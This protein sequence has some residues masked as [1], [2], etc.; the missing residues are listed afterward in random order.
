MD[1]HSTPGP[2]SLSYY[3]ELGLNCNEQEDEQDDPTPQSLLSS[4]QSNRSDI[5][6]SLFHQY[7]LTPL[8]GEPVYFVENLD[9]T[10]RVRIRIPAH[11]TPGPEHAKPSATVIR[12]SSFRRYAL[13]YVSVYWL[14]V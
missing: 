14:C 5:R 9:L 7:R 8:Y 10:S 4:I 11:P 3:S 13:T 6:G 12:F 1:P 2:S